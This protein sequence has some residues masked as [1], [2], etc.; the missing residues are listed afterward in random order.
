MLVNINQRK[1]YLTLVANDFFLS[2]LSVE[3][4]EIAFA[5]ILKRISKI[6]KRISNGQSSSRIDLIFTDQ[7]SQSKNFKVSSSIQL[8]CHYHFFL[9][10]FDLDT[11]ILHTNVSWGTPFWENVFRDKKFRKAGLDFNKMILNKFQNFVRNKIV[12][13]NDKDRFW[14]H[15]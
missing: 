1:L 2:L 8:K 11:F 13:C 3:K 12:T 4:N 14:I 10:K 5:N 6:F 7:P 15:G 9:S